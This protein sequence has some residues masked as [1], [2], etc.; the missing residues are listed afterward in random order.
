MN[1]NDLTN[2]VLGEVTPEKSREIQDA[3][4]T[5]EEDQVSEVELR[6]LTERLRA[7][8]REEL[9]HTQGNA[10]PAKPRIWLDPDW[11]SIRAVALILICAVPIILAI[12]G[13]SHRA[14]P[15]TS[16]PEPA[17]E[18]EGEEIAPEV[19]GNSRE[20]IAVGSQ[21]TSS[22][23]LLVPSRSY[24]E[25]KKAIGAGD[26]AARSK[27]RV[28]ALINHF[29]DAV[30]TDD[31]VVGIA[32]E[33]ASCPW[34]ADSQ[35]VRVTLSFREQAQARVEVKFIEGAVDSYRLLGY[36]GGDGGSLAEVEEVPAGDVV[37][38]IYEVRGASAKPVPRQLMIVSIISS[39]Q[40][41]LASS[42]VVDHGEKFTEATSNFHLVVAAA[43]LGM[44]VRE[45][46]PVSAGDLDQ[47]H[48]WISTS[49][50]DKQQ[51]LDQLV[52]KV[53]ATAR[54]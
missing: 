13:L 29:Q 52:T 1:E 45:E 34:S 15:V 36:E 18:M 2:Y 30:V 38:A 35:L 28:E 49:A 17:L 44:I 4:S 46:G 10:S 31:G 50:G 32:S 47:I 40:Q 22:F 51:E 41:L 53:K 16:R 7:E 3:L 9:E 43:R 24:E 54:L 11:M 21:R 42:E 8:Y 20:F 39:K 19:S 33:V 48:S 5:S 25:A 27:V 37:T 6:S 23:P 14:A 12:S 26:G